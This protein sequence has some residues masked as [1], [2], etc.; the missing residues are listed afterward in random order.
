VN[1]GQAATVIKDEEYDWS[2]ELWLAYELCFIVQQ[3]F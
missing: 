2:Y 1:P 3:Q